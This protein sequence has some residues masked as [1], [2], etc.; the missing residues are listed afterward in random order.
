M[1]VTVQFTAQERRTTGESQMRPTKPPTT[2]CDPETVPE[3]EQPSTSDICASRPTN[4]PTCWFEPVTEPYALTPFTRPP[5][6][7]PNRP[8]PDTEEFTTKLEMQWF[9]P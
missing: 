1:N 6:M 9:S 7:Q 2:Y 3:N 5:A 8:A 4:P